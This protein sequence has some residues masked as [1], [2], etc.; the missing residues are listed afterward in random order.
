MKLKIKSIK[1][2]YFTKT[3]SLKRK[4]LIKKLLLE[5]YTSVEFSSVYGILSFC[6]NDES[7]EAEFILWSTACGGIEI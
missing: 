6:F 7:E 2:V 3:E 5:K 1:G 4:N